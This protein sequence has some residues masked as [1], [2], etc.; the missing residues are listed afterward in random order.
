MEYV[1]IQFGAFCI[2]QRD[3][4]GDRG[5]ESHAGRA[6]PMGGGQGHVGGLDRS[7]A[8][9]S[10]P[11]RHG[12]G[13]CPFEIG[14]APFRCGKPLQLPPSEGVWDG[15]PSCHRSQPEISGKERE[16]GGGSGAP[17]QWG[18]SRSGGGSSPVDGSTLSEGFGSTRRQGIETALLGGA[19]SSGAREGMEGR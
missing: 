3:A 12:Y 19:S 1:G 15:L 4:F 7:G 18:R 6:F 11:S 10:G 5:M 2:V 14:E 9:G 13:E 17:P 8:G 16:R